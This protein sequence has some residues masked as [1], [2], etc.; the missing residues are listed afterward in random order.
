MDGV[1]IPSLDAKDIYI[2]NYL[3]PKKGYNLKRKNGTYN[4]S[5][6]K[7]ALDFS[8]DLIKLREVY[9]KVYRNQ[10]FSWYEKNEMEYTDRVINVTFK[11]SNKILF[12]LC[13]ASSILSPEVIITLFVVQSSNYVIL[14]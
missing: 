3:Y 4:L 2:A 13:I 12:L 1:K 14:R 9:Y 10:K 8:L 6:F 5:R 7:N 11:Y